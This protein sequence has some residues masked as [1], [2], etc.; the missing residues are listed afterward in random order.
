MLRYLPYFLRT[1]Q[2]ITTHFFQNPVLQSTIGFQAYAAGSPPDLGMGILIFVA[3]CEHLGIYYPR[4]GMD[5]LPESIR[6]AG[7]EFDLEVRL[8]QKVEKILLKTL[9]KTRT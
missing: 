7:E 5:A 9:L 8:E 6:R 3:L 4:G 1:S 2:G